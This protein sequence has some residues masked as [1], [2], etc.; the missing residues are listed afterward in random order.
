MKASNLYI[1]IT[2]V[3][4]WWALTACSSERAAIPASGK[5]SPEAVDKALAESDA[6]FK[7]RDDLDKLRASIKG[8]TAV[9]NSDNRNYQVEWT[10]AKHNYLLGK[11]SPNEDEAEEAL[12]MGRDAGKIASRLEPHKPEGHFW[13]AANLGELAKRSP[14]T[15]GLM[16]V[17]DIKESM[18]KVVELQPD[19]QGAS[20]Y[21]ALAQVELGTKLKGGDALKAV[22]YLE[23]GLQLA[24]E[25]PNIRL[26]LAEAYLAVKR[27]AEARKQLDHLLAVK[28]DPRYVPEYRECV[29]KAKKLLS[30]NF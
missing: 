16:S 2:I 24:P 22:D 28:P 23:K 9:R 4:T 20:A 15:V 25:N 12:E 10:F 5:A 8:L 11:F 18:G 13:Y 17:D 27:D 1:L 14:I 7:Q 6:L 30:S 26:H 19:Y 29:E 3:I 21:D